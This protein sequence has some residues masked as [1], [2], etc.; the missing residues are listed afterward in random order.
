MAMITDLT[1]GDDQRGTIRVRTYDNGPGVWITITRS[2]EGSVRLTRDDLRT[3]SQLDV[4]P[5]GR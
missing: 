5:E 4:P 2:S 3:L 1:L